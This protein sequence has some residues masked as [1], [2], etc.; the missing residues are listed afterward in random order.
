QEQA[1]QGEHPVDHGEAAEV[2]LLGLFLPMLVLANWG[3]GSYLALPSA[4]IEG[5]YQVAGFVAA[6]LVIWLGA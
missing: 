5:L 3:S 4:L 6:A 2:A 1:E